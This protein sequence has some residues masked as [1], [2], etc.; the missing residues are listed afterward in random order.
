MTGEL[1]WHI[2][3]DRLNFEDISLKNP[4]HVNFDELRVS[5]GAAVEVADGGWYPNLNAVGSV[6]KVGSEWPPDQQRW[7]LGLTLTFPF[8][9]GTSQISASQTARATRAQAED[10]EHSTDF[11]LVAGL[12]NAYEAFL[13]AAGQVDVAQAFLVGAQARSKIA[14]VDYGAGL[15][16]FEDWTVIDSDLVT[17]EQNLLQNQLNA[18]QAEAT[19]ESAMGV[20]DIK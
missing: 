2:P 6:G 14:N 16:T 18:M 19:W 17:R 1:E 12:E 7:S 15:M 9:A 20:G 3:K 4:S 11:K 10:Q 13:D 8:F 5:A